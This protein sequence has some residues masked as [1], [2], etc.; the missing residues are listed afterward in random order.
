VHVW[1][2]GTAVCQPSISAVMR[3]VAQ[4]NTLNSTS[5]REFVTGWLENNNDLIGLTKLRLVSAESPV[6]KLSGW[7]ETKDLLIDL[8]VWENA[9]CLDIEVIDKESKQ[10]VFS[11]QGPC[12]DIDGLSARLQ[13]FSQCISTFRKI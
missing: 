13:Q 2:S 3:G 4:I 11:E 12:G 7:Y 10:F 5:A 6:Q 1:R 9:C 8:S